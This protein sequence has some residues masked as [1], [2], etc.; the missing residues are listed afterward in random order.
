MGNGFRTAADVRAQ[1]SPTK[2][3]AALAP[4]LLSSGVMEQGNHWHTLRAR[5]HARESRSNG[6]VVKRLLLLACAGL[7][8]ASPA[9]AAGHPLTPAERAHIGVLIDRF[10]KDAVRRENLP[11]AWSLLGPGIRG[12]TTKAGWDSGRAVTV[13]EYPAKGNDFRNAWTGTVVGP[14]DVIVAMMFHPDSAHPNVPQTAFK[15]EVIRRGSRWIVNGF[16]PAATFYGGGHVEGPADFSADGGARSV[17]VTHGQMSGHWFEVAVAGIAALVVLVPLGL[18]L[19]A[20]RRSR[21][22]Y[23]AFLEHR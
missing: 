6:Q 18:W 10:V 14:G 7:A 15:A 3:D 13:G 20:R 22:A 2:D 4:E 5:L 8:L 1:S 23:A 19:R 21:R 16:Y 9:S 11:A 17:G 12:G